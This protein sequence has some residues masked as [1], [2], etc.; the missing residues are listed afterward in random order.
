MSTTKIV[1]RKHPYYPLI[2]I[3]DRAKGKDY[4]F[5][6][7]SQVASPDYFVYVIHIMLTA[8][9]ND[10]ITF[11]INTP[12]GHVDSGFGVINAMKRCLAPITTNIV[13][14]AYSCGAYI[15]A[16]GDIRLMGRFARGMFH[17][18]SHGQQGRT[19]DIKERAVAIEVRLMTLLDEIVDK[20]VLTAEQRD[21]CLENKKDVY[22]TSKDLLP[23][24]EGAE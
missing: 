10:T 19:R 5:N 15:W 3:T 13:G 22:F 23:A 18:S 17:T 16:Y 11:L 6:I 8:T 20:G 12:G 21:K 2:S 14:H 4:V 9:K 24:K 1:P 7:D